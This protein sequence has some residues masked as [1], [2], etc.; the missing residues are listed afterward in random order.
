MGSRCGKHLAALR[1]AGGHALPVAA[2]A[3]PSATTGGLLLR[4]SRARGGRPAPAAK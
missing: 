2:A 3:V 4:R 1:A